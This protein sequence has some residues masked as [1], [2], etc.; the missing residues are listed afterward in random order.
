MAFYP[1]HHY[2]RLPS[3]PQKKQKTMSARGTRRDA[4]SEA[5]GVDDPLLGIQFDEPGQYEEEARGGLD[6]SSFSFLN[7]R[8]QE[9]E[10]SKARA[11]D[12]SPSAAAAAYAKKRRR[13]SD[14]PSAASAGSRDSATNA[15]ASARRTAMQKKTPAKVAHSSLL[16]QSCRLFPKI[17]SVIQSS[18]EMEP[19]QAC[20]RAVKASTGSSYLV[21]DGREPY[22]LPINILLNHQA[23]LESLLVLAK[24]A[25]KALTLKDGRDEGCSVIIAL[26]LHGNTVQKGDHGK[27]IPEALLGVNQEAAQVHDKRRNFPLHVAT[28]VGAS[29][30]MINSLYWA[31]PE[32]LLEKNFYGETPLD[33]AIR[34]GKCEDRVTNFLHEKID[35]LKTARLRR[36]ASLS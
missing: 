31:F 14:S 29:F 36:G 5:S 1:A 9:A 18:V 21:G 8:L 16:H 7:K 33:I 17:A 20:K 22:S 23:S 12:D 34:N 30:S 19:Q 4:L 27:S 25:P 10:D 11:Q 24:A 35:H 6:G 13:G 3:A 26:R 28:Y 32:A 2:S 15:A